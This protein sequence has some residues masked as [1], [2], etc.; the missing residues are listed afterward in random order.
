MMGGGPE[1]RV[2]SNASTESL[3]GRLNQIDIRLRQLERQQQQQSHELDKDSVAAVSSSAAAKKLTNDQNVWLQ[4]M[5]EE[6]MKQQDDVPLLSRRE[7][8]AGAPR[9]NGDL[10]PFQRGARELQGQLSKLKIKDARREAINAVEK[11]AN[12]MRRNEKRRQEHTR[13]YKKWFPVGC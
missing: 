1:T 13:L 5:E 8:V 11:R 7:I 2:L 4:Q 6:E 9:R 3:L 12:S 10:F